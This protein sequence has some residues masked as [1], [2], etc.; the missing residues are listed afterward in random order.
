MMSG[1][2][3]FSALVGCLSLLS[4]SFLGVRAWLHP[5]DPEIEV[6]PSAVAQAP[7]ARTVE[8]PFA[9]KID[10]LALSDD[11]L[12]QARNTLSRS[13]KDSFRRAHGCFNPDETTIQGSVRAVFRLSARGG[14]LHAALIG[15]PTFL[16]ER[17][18]QVDDAIRGCLISKVQRE[19]Q[20]APP[21]SRLTL[22]GDLGQKTFDIPVGGNARTCSM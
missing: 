4:A 6:G 22:E 13:L 7:A 17:N 16:P 19:L 3:M 8:I 20:V 5:D 21:R 14:H 10:L 1:G 2:F 12:F 18:S 11:G 9:A 15:E